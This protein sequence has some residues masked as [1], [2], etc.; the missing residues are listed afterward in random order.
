MKTIGV[1]ANQFLLYHTFSFLIHCYLSNQVSIDQSSFSFLIQILI[2]LLIFFGF[3]SRVIKLE[4]KLQIFLTY[5]WHEAE[6]WQ[7]CGLPLTR[8]WLTCG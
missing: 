1:L 7:T 2:F 6:L 3:L 5:G 8:I 4:R